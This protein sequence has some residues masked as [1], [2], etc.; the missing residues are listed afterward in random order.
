MTST[1]KNSAIK[2]EAPSKS[3]A[4]WQAF[5]PGCQAH[6]NNSVNPQLALLN[7]AAVVAHSLSFKHSPAFCGGAKLQEPRAVNIIVSE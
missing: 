3:S 2:T 5:V 7:G 4:L 1:S 6:L